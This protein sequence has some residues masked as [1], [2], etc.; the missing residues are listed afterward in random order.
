MCVCVCVASVSHAGKRKRKRRRLRMGG[1][2]REIEICF[3]TDITQ[4][5]VVQ[6]ELESVGTNERPFLTSKR[7]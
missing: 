6:H 7:H 1:G 2:Y 3:K 5:L 4:S